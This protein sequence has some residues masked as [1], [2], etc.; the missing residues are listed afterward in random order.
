M[1]TAPQPIPA[2]IVLL[3]QNAT[4]IAP[5]AGQAANTAQQNAEPQDTVKLTNNDPAAGEAAQVLGQ[6]QVQIQEA[7]VVAEVVTL[8][9]LNANAPGNANPAIAVNA[10]A[11]DPAAANATNAATAT[12]ANNLAAA[13]A[14]TG[15][16]TA[17]NTAQTVQQEELAHLDKVLGQLGFSP[18]SIP[19]VQQLAMFL[20][21][22]DPQ[23]LLQFVNALQGITQQ[24]GN[25][26]HINDATLPAQ[27][28]I[29][30]ANA[31]A[32]RNG[33]F[34]AQFQEL[35]LSFTAIAIDPAGANTQAAASG[36]GAAG[37]GAAQGAA[38]NVKA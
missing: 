25:Q 27:Q 2:L 36:A 38:L 22:F 4:Q 5:A 1:A 8:P 32:G 18:S 3:F 35:Q 9:Q 29:A 31:G 14:N 34:A 6:V 16:K 20:F 37:G 17:N 7:A 23:A 12:A 28:N 24:I 21:R 13:A 26:A 11:P 15:A 10:A 19:I 33:A 30:P